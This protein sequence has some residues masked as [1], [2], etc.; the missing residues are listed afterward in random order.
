M[1]KKLQG[2]IKAE[3][4][5]IDKDVQN[6]K[7]FID[8][9]DNITFKV[10]KKSKSNPD[11]LLDKKGKNLLDYLSA[12]QKEKE[13][14]YQN[15][16]I[17]QIKEKEKKVKALLNRKIQDLNKKLIKL[18]NYEMEKEKN[19]KNKIKVIVI[20]KLDK[21]HNEQEKK[22]K[23]II[24]RIKNDSERKFKFRRNKF[25]KKIIPLKEIN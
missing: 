14:H 11:P 13:S 20:E 7:K 3:I 23:S 9:N 22:K 2:S 10:E 12:R 8:K 24:K 16:K 25:Y 21:N 6:F 4:K 15:K 5:N 1:E 17:I 18:N 19:K